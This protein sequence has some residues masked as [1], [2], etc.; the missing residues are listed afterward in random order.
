MSNTNNLANL[1][2]VQE[3]IAR[4]I[5][6]EMINTFHQGKLQSARTSISNLSS[7]NLNQV[8]QRIINQI[9]KVNS[10]PAFSQLIGLFQTLESNIESLI[11]YKT[12]ELL[13]NEQS[14]KNLMKNIDALWQEVSY[15]KNQVPNAYEKGKFLEAGIAIADEVEDQMYNEIPL[16][17]VSEFLTVDKAKKWVAGDKNVNINIDGIE[18]TIEKVK[19]KA[20]YVVENGQRYFDFGERGSAKISVNALTNF[21]QK[22]DAELTLPS[23][24][25]NPLIPDETFKISAKNWSSTFFHSFGSTSMAYAI[26]RSNGN[27]VDELLSYGL[28]SGWPNNNVASIHQWAKIMIVLDHIVGLGQ[29]QGTAADTL[30]INNRSKSRIEV[31]STAEILDKI[32]KNIDNI[33]ING[34]SDVQKIG[35]E[36]NKHLSSQ[37]YAN[38]IL[39]HL[40]S[41]MVSISTGT[42]LF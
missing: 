20:E 4:D 21:K 11:Q 12:G 31:Y 29:G 23:P 7:A 14:V 1:N 36:Y 8:R 34:Y 9:K 16:A 37:D 10:I 40:R 18:V 17:L 41:T 35:L 30:V 2:D 22:V 42:N 27:N 24:K 15:Q 3:R 28:K 6:Q 39:S 19:Q 32:V 5:Q 26:L 13:L 33:K 25:S 38:K